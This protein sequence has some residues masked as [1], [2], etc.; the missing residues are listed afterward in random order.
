M[1]ICVLGPGFLGRT[2]GRRL[3]ENSNFHVTMV[4]S[5]INWSDADLSGYDAIVNCAGNSA[6][7]LVEQDPDGAR[8]SENAI[9]DRIRSVHKANP[10]V[11][12]LHM[13]SICARTSD[14]SEYGKLKRQTETWAG[15]TSDPCILRLCGLIGPRLVKNFIF[16]LTN[17]NPIRVTS[18][19]LYNFISTQEVG[20]ITEHILLNWKPNETFN[21]GA[22]T[23]M[24]VSTMVKM[25]E[26]NHTYLSADQLV[27][28]TYQIDTSKLQGF[29]SVKTTQ[30]YVEEYLKQWEKENA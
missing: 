26:F 5:R 9:F 3:A 6:R 29:F 13:S 18:D 1:N 8:T 30:Q 17:G 27:K 11:K 21:V 24:R 12:L 22:S 19:T 14:T 16:D 2:V 10:N 15:E 23:S 4:S 7:Y 28:E 20:N 25:R